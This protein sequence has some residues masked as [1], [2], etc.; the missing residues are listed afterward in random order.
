MSINIQPYYPIPVTVTVRIEIYKTVIQKSVSKYGVKWNFNKHQDAPSGSLNGMQR[1]LTY[2]TCWCCPR[3]GFRPS[4][5]F[6]EEKQ[7]DQ[8]SS[9]SEGRLF[10]STISFYSGILY[11]II[12]RHHLTGTGCPVAFLFTID[13]SMGTLANFLG[14]L[15][16]TVGILNIYKITIDVSSRYRVGCDP[17][18]IPFGK[19]TKVLVPRGRNLDR[20]N[21]TIG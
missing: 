16:N 10:A 13:Q 4:M 19:C 20:K 14:L 2:R 6:A 8:V 15:R 12:T 21:P 17:R 5:R 9:H 3:W 18:S 1:Q 7:E 11:T